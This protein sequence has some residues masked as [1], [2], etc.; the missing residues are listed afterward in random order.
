MKK[1]LPLI[2]FLC[3]VAVIGT[4]LVKEGLPSR[5]PPQRPGEIWR[6]GDPIYGDITVDSINRFG[7]VCYHYNDGLRSRCICD[8]QYFN[9][10]K[11]G[12]AKAVSDSTNFIYDSLNTQK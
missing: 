12:G 11:V 7:S 1:H 8:M 5:Q 6:C 3:A 9:G 2:L 4:I 10:E